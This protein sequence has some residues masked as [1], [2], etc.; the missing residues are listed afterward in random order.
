MVMAIQLLPPTTT[1]RETQV[2]VIHY[3][4]FSD[5]LN[6][7]SQQREDQITFSHEKPINQLSLCF[8]GYQQN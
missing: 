5:L 2:H 4:C 3:H 8:K 6:K 1:R 7:F